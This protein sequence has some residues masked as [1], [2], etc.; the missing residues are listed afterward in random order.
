MPRT[1]SHSFSPETTYGCLLLSR[2]H[3]TL[4]CHITF[5]LESLLLI[6][7]GQM[8]ERF[9]MVIMILLVLYCGFLFFIYIHFMP[10]SAVQVKDVLLLL[11]V[12]SVTSLLWSFWKVQGANWSVTVLVACDVYSKCLTQFVIVNFN[13]DNVLMKLK[14]CIQ[15]ISLAQKVTDFYPKVTNNKGKHFYLYII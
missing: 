12:Q 3:I 1:N 11:P 2:L 9:I 13:W 14:G 15:N 5:L 7:N 8:F 10:A 4:M 6:R